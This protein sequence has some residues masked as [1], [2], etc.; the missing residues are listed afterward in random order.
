[1]SSSCK[2]RP[3]K[4]KHSFDTCYNARVTLFFFSPTVAR[5]ASSESVHVEAHAGEDEESA[6]RAPINLAKE[7]C[8]WTSATMDPS[9]TEDFREGY[10]LL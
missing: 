6:D 5:F 2:H 1:M 9:A 4:L 8:K 7:I 3:G 10:K